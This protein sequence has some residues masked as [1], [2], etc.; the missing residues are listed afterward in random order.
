MYKK[1]TAFPLL[2]AI[3][4]AILYPAVANSQEQASCTVSID[5]TNVPDLY[6]R[7]L[8]LLIQVN[9]ASN[10]LVLQNA[11]PVPFTQMG[12]RLII[13]TPADSLSVEFT[14]GSNV[15]NLC[16]VEK[17]PLLNNKRWVW[18]HGFDDNVNLLPAIEEFRAKSWPATVFMI[19]KDYDQTREENNWI[20]D[21]P[22]V[23]QILLPEGWAIGSHSWNHERFETSDPTSENYL[24]DILDGQTH[25]EAS[26]ARSSVPGFQVMVFASPNFSS[27]YDEPFNDAVKTTNLKLLEVGNDSL[28]IVTG[29]EPY[30]AGENRSIPP[31]AGRIKIGRD[32]AIGHDP[33]SAVDKIDWMA[34]NASETHRFWY[35]TLAHGGSEDNIKAVLDHVWSNYGPG[36][37]NEVWVASSTEV[38]SYILTRDHATISV[39]FSENIQETSS[40]TTPQVGDKPVKVSLP[41]ITMMKNW[42][43]LHKKSGKKTP[44]PSALLR[45]SG[46][47]LQQ[48]KT[49]D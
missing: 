1:I 32:S 41:L 7:N 26:V 28:L 3:L 33:E 21:E 38:Y 14:P 42:M 31:L 49:A 24:I 23:N 30:A 20:T 44:I 19:A 27:E 4:F 45:M 47:G 12:D 16:G 40:N 9:N 39:E 25:I 17:A 15:D 2:L 46:R 18:S 8:T 34:A 13:T 35:N 43:K 48:L 29:D 11:Q 37:T 5:R 10:I 22:Y 36:G 6:F